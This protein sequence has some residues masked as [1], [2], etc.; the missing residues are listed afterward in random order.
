MN[1][2]SWKDMADFLLE[3]RFFTEQIDEA[4]QRRNE[5]GLVEAL[6]DLQ[7][8]LDDIGEAI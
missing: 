6:A 2:S 5:R 1:D 3:L 4:I 7:Q 8:T